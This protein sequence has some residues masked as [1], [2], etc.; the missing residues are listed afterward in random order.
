MK[1]QLLQKQDETGRIYYHIMKDNSHI[2]NT[3]T[4]NFEEA[5]TFYNWVVANH[6]PAEP[7]VL[8]ETEIGKK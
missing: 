3:V 1:I 7:I 8:M 4:F 2:P 5:V 6:T